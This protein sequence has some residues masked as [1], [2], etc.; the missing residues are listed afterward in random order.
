MVFGANLI[1]IRPTVRLAYLTGAMLMIPLLVLLVGPFLTGDWSA[2]RL[3]WHLG[4]AGQTWGG[5]KLVIVWL[6]VMLWTSLGVETC[7]TFAPEYRRPARDSS[8]ALRVAALFSLGVFVVLPISITG[9]T[10]EQPAID[11]PVGFYIVTFDRIGGG[12]TDLMV[13][14]VVGSLMLVMLTSMAGG[15]R[16]LYG[17]ADERLTL[18]QLHHLNRFGVPSRCLAIDSSPTSA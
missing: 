9:L 15:S 6:Y 13:A 3:S 10:G 14:F 1:G 17:I 8:I 11:D 5:W 7:A 2:S 4:E 18:R 16:A 12:I